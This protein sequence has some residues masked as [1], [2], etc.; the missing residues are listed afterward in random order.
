MLQA[1]GI[2]HTT[3]ADGGVSLTFYLLT[4]IAQSDAL[5]RN[6]LSVS[7]PGAESRVA[8]HP[9]YS[10]EAHFLF[11]GGEVVG[12]GRPQYCRNMV[13]RVV[14]FWVSRVFPCEVRGKMS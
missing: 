1:A 6:A 10:T 11:D 8:A 3:T 4:M 2:F 14:K 7:K 13:Y 12:A 5:V 9:K